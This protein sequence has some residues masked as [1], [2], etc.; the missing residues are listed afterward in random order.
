MHLGTPE[1]GGTWERMCKTPR[2]LRQHNTTHLFL[3]L[4]SHQL[5][6]L[7][8]RLLLYRGDEGGWRAVGRPYDDPTSVAVN[9]GID[10]GSG[11]NLTKL[12]ERIHHDEAIWPQELKNDAADVDLEGDEDDGSS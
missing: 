8:S 5:L 4:S 7:G 10:A 6:Y 1:E 12:W 9:A 11:P 2:L 3:P